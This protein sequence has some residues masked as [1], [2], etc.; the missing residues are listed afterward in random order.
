LQEAS[1]GEYAIEQFKFEHTNDIDKVDISLEM[2]TDDT[3]GTIKL[4]IY[5]YTTTSWEDMDTATGISVN[6]DF[7]LS[8]SKTGADYYDTNNVVTCRVYQFQA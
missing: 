5:N 6:T 3:A 1:A 8:G 4:Q 7:T 2:Q